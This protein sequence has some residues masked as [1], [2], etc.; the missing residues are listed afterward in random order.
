M[1]ISL[2]ALLLAFN[3]GGWVGTWAAS[4]AGAGTPTQFDKQTLREIVHTSIG[5]SR[6]RVRLS[7]AFGA[8]PLV[9]GA[10]HVAL[11]SSGSSVAS[12]HALTFSGQT[13]FSI[14][15]GALA[16]S[17]PVALEVRAA[18][19]VAVSIYLPAATPGATAHASA[20]QTSFVA[21]GDLT[22][23]VDLPAT[24]VKITS[25]PFLA[26][27]DVSGSRKME[28]IVAFG[29]SI[30]DGA[31]STNDANTR[32]P[33]VLAQRL[34][35]KFAVLNQGIGG[36]RVLH[37]GTGRLAAVGQSALARFDRDVLAQPGVKYVI[38]LEGINDIGFPG[39]VG[40]E[41]EEV[42]ADQIIAGLQQL[43]ERAHERGLRIFGGTL[44]PFEGTTI[45]K[46]Y[47]PEREPKRQAV[48]QWIRTSKA[49]DAVIDFEKAVQDPS[50]PTR[51]LAQYDSGDHL[52]PSDAGYKAM[53]GAIDLK[54]FR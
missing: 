54:L 41:S 15:A 36:N 25:W 4:P 23:A 21:P 7:N 29:D 52:H 33:D 6:V 43:V 48:N 50:H 16:L 32:W 31:R 1:T 42:T 2:L 3:D 14:P 22:G 46:Y 30:T 53:A 12:D 8:Q 44:T 27:V 17:D 18:S 10:A 40:G 9:I 47:A 5:G 24:A 45:P 37:D 51:I 11:R 19:D 38:V 13:S 35:A 39:A 34:H 49:F 28:A 26:G 20:Q